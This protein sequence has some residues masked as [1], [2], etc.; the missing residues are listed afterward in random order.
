[1][2]NNPPN[3]QDE[4]K[5]SFTLKNGV[6]VELTK[7]DVIDNNLYKLTDKIPEI[8]LSDKLTDS[9]PLKKLLHMFESGVQNKFLYYKIL[10]VIFFCCLWAIQISAFIQHSLY[11]LS[12]LLITLWSSSIIISVQMNINMKDSLIRILQN[13]FIVIPLFVLISLAV[14]LLIYVCIGD[15]ILVPQNTIEAFIKMFSFEKINYTIIYPLTGFIFTSILLV[16]YDINQRYCNYIIR[17]NLKFITTPLFIF[18]LIVIGC[19][20]YLLT[21]FLPNE[22]KFVYD[23][24]NSL[25]FQFWFLISL[26]F[27]VYTF[28]YCFILLQFIILKNIIKIFDN[29]Y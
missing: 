5:Y 16:L 18:T 15:N 11:Q 25:F 3:V 10:S 6:V 27:I 28:I 9:N 13:K 4:K 1:M 19:F 2:K 22:Q 21:I 29:R 12:M 14:T 17:I 24:F 26:F 7:Q 23:F 8:H 20:F